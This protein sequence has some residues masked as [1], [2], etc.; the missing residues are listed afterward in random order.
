MA[1]KRINVSF[2]EDVEIGTKLL[3][4]NA[5]DH[6]DPTGYGAISYRLENTK[7]YYSIDSKTGEVFLAS[8]FDYENEKLDEVNK[9]K[10]RS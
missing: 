10:H 7:S 3:Q 2:R 1:E 9:N 8:N 6:D 4:V 5:I